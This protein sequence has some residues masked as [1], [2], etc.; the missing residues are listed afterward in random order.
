MFRL[1]LLC[2]SCISPFL[3]AGSIQEK[4]IVVII[5]SY[6]NSKWVRMNLYS[7]LDQGYRNFRVIYIN[8]CSKDNTADL[9]EKTVAELL[10][11]R[12]WNESRPLLD[13]ASFDD[14]GMSIQDAAIAFHD[15]V[16]KRKAFITVINNKNRCGALCN[17]YRGIY[18]CDDNEI[19]VTV[20]GDDWLAHGRVLREL[21]QVYVRENVW[22]THG[23]LMEFPGGGVTWCEPIPDEII[24]K[25]AFRDFKCPSH[26]R[27]FYAWL[28]KKI[29]LEDLLYEG[30]FFMMTWDM[31]MMYPMIEMARERHAFIAKP[32]YVYNMS[33]SINDNKVNPE[34]Q[35]MLDCILRNAKRY[36]RLN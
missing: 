29:Q 31:A 20:D 2:F 12:P 10:G 30:K 6:N 27:T 33:N 16:V 21:N 15:L 14:R 34:L 11:A 22:M 23:S 18:S 4:P 1:I 25:N 7:V 36:E 9:V 35:N 32:N 3:S 5:P 8:D 13:V 24:E 26:L 19:V 17:L 28:F